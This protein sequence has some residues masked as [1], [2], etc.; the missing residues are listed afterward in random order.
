MKRL[1]I[2]IVAAGAVSG[3]AAT[4]P[5]DDPA[6]VHVLGRTGFGPRPGDV[7]RVRS[8]G[9]QRYLDEQLRPERIND[10]QVAARLAG[11][12]T[13]GMSSRKIA[14]EYEI[15]QLEARRQ[16][17]ADAKGSDVTAADGKQP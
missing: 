14:E 5:T 6:I 2:L 1:L 11:L 16:R 8:V 7:E 15:P 9:I 4:S 12:T 10:A 17:Q 13:I 3:L